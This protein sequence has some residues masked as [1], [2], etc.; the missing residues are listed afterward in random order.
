MS[1][2]ALLSGVLGLAIGAV[3]GMLVVE[4]KGLLAGGIMGRSVGYAFHFA[5][6]GRSHQ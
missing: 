4:G 3:L 5:T 2:Q 1:S 6:G